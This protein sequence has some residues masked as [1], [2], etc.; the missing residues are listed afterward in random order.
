MFIWYD[1]LVNPCDTD[2][3]STL[4]VGNI[5]EEPI[6]QIWC[7][8]GYEKLREAHLNKERSKLNPCRR[9]VVI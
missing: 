2:Y 7:S 3:K 6:S 9:C 8:E 4:S 5:K 1:G